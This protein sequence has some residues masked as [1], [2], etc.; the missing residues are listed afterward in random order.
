MIT[1]TNEKDNYKLLVA[2]TM[3]LLEDETDLLANMANIS[4]VLYHGL[5][6]VNWVGFYILKG[7]D[8]VL[9]PFQGLPACTR[10]PLGKGVCGTAASRKQ[11]INVDDVHQF[12][13]HIACDSASRSECVLPIIRNNHVVAV[14]DVD[15]PVYSRFDDETEHCLTQVVNI[16][17]ESLP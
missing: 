10:I 7:N 8:L 4:A 16:L 12:E 3:A 5:S 1:T 14:L 13:G 2:Q 6:E 11:L 15:S 17:T 9:G